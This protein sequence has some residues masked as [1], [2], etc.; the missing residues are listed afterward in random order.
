MAKTAEEFLSEA[1]PNIIERLD[2][3]E[4]QAAE[5]HTFIFEDTADRPSF[6]T[7]ALKI[8]RHVN[9]LCDWASLIRRLLR[10]AALVLKWLA[11][12]A[13]SLAALW[14]VL[15]TTGLT[16][17]QASAGVSEQGSFH[18]YLRTLWDSRRPAQVGVLLG[19]GLL[20]IAANYFYK[21]LTRQSNGSLWHYL[22]VDN[23]RRTLASFA[24]YAGW[25]FGVA[26][27]SDMVTD[28]TTWTAI[29]NLALTTGFAIDVVANKSTR[30]AWTPAEREAAQPKETQ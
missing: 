30:A 25:I 15:H 4:G 14:G 18:E 10:G 11:I 20:G 12:I 23:P 17:A 9:V 8:D 26:F 6:Q 29:I 13:T 19:F 28:A 1:W 3:L 22:A 21:W 2:N 5:M 16:Y 7:I 24:A 27:P